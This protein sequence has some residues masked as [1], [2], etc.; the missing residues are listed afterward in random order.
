MIR[1]PPRSTLFPYTTLFRSEAD[2][3]QLLAHGLHEAGGVHGNVNACHDSSNRDGSPFNNKYG[4]RG[5]GYDA[6]QGGAPGGTDQAAPAPAGATAGP[7]VLTPPTGGR[8]GWSPRR[9]RIYF[10]S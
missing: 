10:T 4:G 6:P 9:P 3:R 5:E 8:A 2:S 7:N 1:R